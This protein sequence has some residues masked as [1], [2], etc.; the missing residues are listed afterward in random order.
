MP[1][2]KKRVE[3]NVTHIPPPLI[4]ANAINKNL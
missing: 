3:K 2:Y 4:T 1:K